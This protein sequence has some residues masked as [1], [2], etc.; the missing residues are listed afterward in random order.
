MTYTISNPPPVAMDD[1]E[2]TDE[3]T[4]LS[5]SVLTDNGN[6]A[7]VDP[8]GDI[9]MV[10]QVNGT[11][12][13]PGAVITLPSGALLTM[14]ADGSY[15]YDPNGQYEGLDVGEIAMDSF[16]YQISDGEGGFSTATVNLTIEGVN[17]API[18]VNPA[19]PGTPPVDPNMVIPAQ[20]G[21]D[22]SCLLYTSPSPRDGLLSRMPSSA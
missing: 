5:D 6:G 4:V 16:T 2:V 7:D 10:T 20:M 14:N 19:D 13:V 3:N 15:D 22:S 18:V 12:I 17:D 1:V 8:D 9:L 11:D 21:D